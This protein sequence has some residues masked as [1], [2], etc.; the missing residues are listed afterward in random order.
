[1]SVSIAGVLGEFAASML[2]IFVEMDVAKIHLRKG[3][4][5]AEPYWIFAPTSPIWR[6]DCG[7]NPAFSV[8]LARFARCSSIREAAPASLNS[9]VIPHAKGLKISVIKRTGSFIASPKFFVNKQFVK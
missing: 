5:C 6:G 1:V 4:C 3:R 7:P 9:G 2:G 8:A